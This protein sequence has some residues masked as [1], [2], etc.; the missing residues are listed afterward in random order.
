MT[1]ENDETTS[2]YE[3]PL[4]YQVVRDDLDAY[5]TDAFERILTRYAG[6]DLKSPG[7]RHNAEIAGVKTLYGETESNSWQTTL[8]TT[9]IPQKAHVVAKVL[10][11]KDKMSQ[12]DDTVDTIESMEQ[13]DECTELKMVRCK[14]VFKTTPRDLCVITTF[15]CEESGRH[16]IVTRSVNHPD[17]T[18][19][20]YTRAYMYISGYIITPDAAD[21]NKCQ[22]AMI[23]HI[24]LSGMVPAFVSKYAGQTVPIKM[25]RSI[26]DIAAKEI[27]A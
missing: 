17:G 25:V 6:N 19:K 2:L 26:R 4:Q 20:G 1:S 10:L 16:L 12:Y 9:S 5:K 7:W 14:S 8:T 22:I 21:R 23:A 18:Q 13:L 11:D 3:S 24:N 27:D 15:K